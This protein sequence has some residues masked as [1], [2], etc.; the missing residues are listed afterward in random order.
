MIQTGEV[1]DP[2]RKGERLLMGIFNYKISLIYSFAC[3]SHPSTLLNRLPDDVA[4]F[5]HLLDEAITR[6]SS[7]N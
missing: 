5:T 7:V 3:F 6:V 1:R 4:F 2:A